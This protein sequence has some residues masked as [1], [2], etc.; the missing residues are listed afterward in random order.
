[1]FYFQ[2]APAQR[3]SRRP[4]T[5]ENGF[6]PSAVFTERPDGRLS[7]VRRAA[8]DTSPAQPPPAKKRR[9]RPP[10][11]SV[12]SSQS[13]QLE[14][15]RYV[16]LYLP[17]PA[18][19]QI[20]APGQIFAPPPM[21]VAQNMTPS[22]MPAAQNVTPPP[23]PVAQ[24]PQS[25]STAMAAENP[26]INATNWWNELGTTS[27][28]DFSTYPSE[29]SIYPQAST[30][31]AVAPK[32]VFP[33]DA[34]LRP[35]PSAPNQTLQSL[36]PTSYPMGSSLDPMPM[37][38]DGGSASVISPQFNLQHEVD[39]F[40]ETPTRVTDTPQ[41]PEMADTESSAFDNQFTMDGAQ[42]MEDF[43]NF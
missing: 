18:P 28:E 12:A 26:G 13:Q 7:R 31:P 10:K 14:T 42:W 38:R 1:M 30:M 43:L 5:D 17:G 19:G 21:P 39:A 20:Y 27:P 34:L 29:M 37:M 25:S 32:S 41:W 23:M 33:A 16:P 4:E 2:A 15:F 3:P 11:N 22:P 36:G 8:R 6:Y 40:R 35:E 24:V 9:G